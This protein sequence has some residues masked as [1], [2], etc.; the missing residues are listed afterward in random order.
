MRGTLNRQRGEKK[1]VTQVTAGGQDI[2]AWGKREDGQ[3]VS[4]HH[5][6]VCVCLRVA[7]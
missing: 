7:C 4:D 1:G 5:L 6:S 3:M 2:A